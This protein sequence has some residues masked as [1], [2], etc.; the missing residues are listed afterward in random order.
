LTAGC[1]NDG[2]Q[3]NQAGYQCV[4]FH[5]FLLCPGY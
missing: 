4:F 5:V 3:H 1:K 2:G